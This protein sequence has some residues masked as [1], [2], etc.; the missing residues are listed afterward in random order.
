MDKAKAELK[1]ENEKMIQIIYT[2][3]S[4]EEDIRDANRKIAEKAD[5][6]K[7]INVEFKVADSHEIAKIQEN[8]Q[9]EAIIITS[10]EI[11]GL[12]NGIKS[13]NIVIVGDSIT[14][15]SATLIKA[16]L[17]NALINAEISRN[18]ESGIKTVKELLLCIF[19]ST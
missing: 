10:D 6:A 2:I 17:P 12:Y 9:T 1:Q 3:K 11:F 4:D 15:S 7:A 13:E 19:T 16:N 5:E 14:L 18:A 8:N